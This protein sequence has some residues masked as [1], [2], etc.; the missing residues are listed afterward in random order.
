MQL[1]IPLSFHCLLLE[2]FLKVNDFLILQRHQA[3]VSQ[4]LSEKGKTGNLDSCPQCNALPSLLGSQVF[5]LH[6]SLG[7]YTSVRDKSH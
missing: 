2:E 7:V 1:P 6:S 3:L 5:G 4:L